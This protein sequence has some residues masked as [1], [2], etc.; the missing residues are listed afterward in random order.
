MTRSTC[1]SRVSTEYG[2]SPSS[3]YLRRSSRVKAVPLLRTGSFSS[4]W[5]GRSASVG[6]NSS[7][8][9]CTWSTRERQHR[10][11][12]HALHAVDQHAFDIRRGGRT[13]VEARIVTVAELRPAIGVVKVHDDIGGI[14]QYDQVLRE[15]GD[16]V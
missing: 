7:M 10:K 2:S 14:E 15:I 8:Y 4:S 11:R 13:G 5:C 16:G 6:C 9:R 3:P 12:A 1:R